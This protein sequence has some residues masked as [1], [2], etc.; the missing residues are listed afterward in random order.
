MEDN[1]LNILFLSGWYPNRVL[2]TLGNFVQKHAEAVALNCNRA[3]LQ[4]DLTE[5]MCGSELPEQHRDR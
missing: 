2:P 3:E 4:C 5:C 1:K